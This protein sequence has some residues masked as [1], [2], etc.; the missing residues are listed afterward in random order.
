MTSGIT[1]CDARTLHR[2]DHAPRRR[3]SAGTL[4][5][6]GLVLGTT[7][8]RHPLVSEME[9]WGDLCISGQL[10]V[11]NLPKYCVRFR[12]PSAHTGAGVGTL[13]AKMVTRRRRFPDPPNPMHRIHEE[14]DQAC[15]Q[16]R[17]SGAC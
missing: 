4:L 3:S 12:R 17:S 9:R 5:V 13:L 1:L 14:A 2:R 11:I 8:H 10:R 7:D 6:R 16:P 15:W